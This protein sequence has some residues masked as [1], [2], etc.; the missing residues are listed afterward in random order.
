MYKQKNHFAEEHKFFTGPHS[1]IS[2]NV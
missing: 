2:Q 1:D